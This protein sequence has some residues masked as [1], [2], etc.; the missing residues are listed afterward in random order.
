MFTTALHSSK[1]AEKWPRVWK[2]FMIGTGDY[3]V[4]HAVRTFKTTCDVRVHN[5][6]EFAFQLMTV[7]L[8][9]TKGFQNLKYCIR[10]KR[11]RSTRS[12]FVSHSSWNLTVSVKL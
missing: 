2:P 6:F 3:Y 9:K 7:A 8:L 10:S 11:F 12:T 5:N 1:Q 4:T